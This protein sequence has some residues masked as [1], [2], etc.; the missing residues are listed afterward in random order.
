MTSKILR[1]PEG[2]ESIMR[3]P[4]PVE[5]SSNAPFIDNKYLQNSFQQQQSISSVDLP[6]IPDIPLGPHA[7]LGPVGNNHFNVSGNIPTA[8]TI[9][10]G[11]ST[12]DL[13]SVNSASR[14]AAGGFD[15]NIP[16][17]PEAVASFRKTEGYSPKTEGHFISKW[18]T[19][20]KIKALCSIAT[21]KKKGVLVQ[22]MSINDSLADINVELT[23]VRRS[24]EVEAS[25]AG[26]KSCLMAGVVLIEMG[27]KFSRRKLNLDK[28]SQSFQKYDMPRCELLLYQI[29]ERQKELA[30]PGQLLFLT[31]V[32][33]AFFFHFSKGMGEQLGKVLGQKV[34]NS[35]MDAFTKDPAKF[36]DFLSGQNTQKKPSPQDEIPQATTFARR[37][38]DNDL[39][40][41]TASPPEEVVI[42][43]NMPVNASDDI[44]MYMP[45][46]NEN[47]SRF[48][49]SNVEGGGNSVP[50]RHNE[51]QHEL[52]SVVESAPASVVGSSNG[53][54]A[55]RRG[56]PRKV[57]PISA[58]I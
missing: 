39:P 14:A 10:Q 24:I 49:G 36:V 37:V 44:P 17:L 52:A 2:I 23:R 6:R 16:T 32:G 25:V 38:P 29:C 26:Y 51:M 28:W 41:V 31:V 11:A 21:Y 13:N 27:N 12:A 33:S 56:R 1:M 8:S 40:P 15:A 53:T 30:G 55:R 46:R 45:P 47:P 18:E 43:V 4:S 9:L 34:G 3:K 5:Q 58:E 19:N 50:S 57:N 48:Q 54:G 7:N 20:Q 35:V 42:P 22:T